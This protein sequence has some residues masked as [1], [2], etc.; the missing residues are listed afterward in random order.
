MVPKNHGATYIRGSQWGDGFNGFY[1][2]IERKV[3][4]VNSS[5]ING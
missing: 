5:T 2:V 3:F 1:A 4:T